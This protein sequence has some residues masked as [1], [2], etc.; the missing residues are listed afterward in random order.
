MEKKTRETVQF[1]CVTSA[2][3]ESGPV[4]SNPAFNHF[5]KFSSYS[6]ANFKNVVI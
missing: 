6:G 2:E 5:A 1:N 3:R 4:Q